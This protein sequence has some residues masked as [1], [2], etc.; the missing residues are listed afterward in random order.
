MKSF[1][2]NNI[3]ISIY[4]TYFILLVTFYLS[5]CGRTWYS[6]RINNIEFSPFTEELISLYLNDSLIVGA[7]QQEYDEITVKIFSDS[8]HYYLCI[9]QNNSS[10]YKYVCFECFVGYFPYQGKTSFGNKTVRVFGERNDTFYTINCKA[11]EQKHCK[12]E[13]WEYDPIEW[14]ICFNSDYTLCYEK[15]DL[16]F[17]EI[18]ITPVVLL[19]NNYFKYKSNP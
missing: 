14:R 8:T 12:K 11:P 4:N 19:V 5:S 16:Y 10:I 3:L 2:R 17:N 18:D 15:T 9:Y 6:N 7:H 1:L 13:Y